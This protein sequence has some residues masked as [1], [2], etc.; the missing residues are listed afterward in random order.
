MREPTGKQRFHV[1]KE[2][3]V[4]AVPHFDMKQSI[5]KYILRK[6]QEQWSSPLLANKKLR[7]IWSPLSFWQ[8]SFH[9]DRRIETVLTQLQMCRCQLTNGFILDGGHAPVCAHCDSFLTVEHILVHVGLPSR[10]YDHFRD[11]RRQ[12]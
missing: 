12:Y 10:W 9:H 4:K 5:H 3:N 8:S 6:W 1:T 7:A 2:M 11:F